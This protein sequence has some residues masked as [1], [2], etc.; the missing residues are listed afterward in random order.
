MFFLFFHCQNILK[1]YFAIVSIEL[2][3]YLSFQHN[4]YI[5]PSLLWVPP[6]KHSLGIFN[7]STISMISWPINNLILSAWPTP[8]GKVFIY[9]FNSHLYLFLCKCG[10]KLSLLTFLNKVIV[11]WMYIILWR[12]T[13]KHSSPCGGV[14]YNTLSQNPFPLSLQFNSMNL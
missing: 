4:S 1:A 13:L 3:G 5:T 7:S 14:P 6:P 9:F 2:L 11:F 8:L 10:F 12:Y